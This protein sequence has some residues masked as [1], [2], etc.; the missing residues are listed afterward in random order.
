MNRAEMRR[1]KREN[2]KKQKTYTLTQVQIDTIKQEAIK[3]AVDRAFLLMLVIPVM[4]LHDKW[5]EKSAKKR[6]SKFVDQ[7][8]DLYDS[9][10]KDYV[11]L[12]DLKQCLEE[13]S[14]VK[15]ERSDN[16]EKYY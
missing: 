10:E 14:G 15:I 1:A 6:C 4:V 9:F 7:C 12:E 13:E 5:W 3:E 2:N 8:L 11:T 16:P